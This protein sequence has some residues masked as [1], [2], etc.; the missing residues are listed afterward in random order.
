M[1]EL[2]PVK[3]KVELPLLIKLVPAAVFGEIEPLIVSAE[4][5]L[6]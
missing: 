6:F 5:L 4:V 1:P 2:P 3:V